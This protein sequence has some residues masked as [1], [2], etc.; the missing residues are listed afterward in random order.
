MEVAGRCDHISFR[1]VWGPVRSRRNLG[2]NGGNFR[3]DQDNTCCQDNQQ[4]RKVAS[5]FCLVSTSVLGNSSLSAISILDLRKSAIIHQTASVDAGVIKFVNGA[6]SPPRGAARSSR[7]VVL[8][9]RSG[10]H[11]FVP[12]PDFGTGC[13]LHHTH[14]QARLLRRFKLSHRRPEGHTAVHALGRRLRDCR[15]VA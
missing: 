11:G 5:H 3:G 8:S 10:P 9:H 15:I 6:I 13:K 4:H 12:G 2:S 7:L 1:Y 14:W